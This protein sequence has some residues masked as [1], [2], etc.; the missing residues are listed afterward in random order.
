MSIHFPRHAKYILTAENT[1]GK[2][3][4]RIASI[5]LNDVFL[6]FS[7]GSLLTKGGVFPRF[8]VLPLSGYYYFNTASRR[9]D[10]K[11]VKKMWQPVGHGVHSS[12]NYCTGSKHDCSKYATNNHFWVFQLFQL[13]LLR[14]DKAFFTLSKRYNNIL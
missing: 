11:H 5:F 1:K 8:Y 3:L 10:R 9:N 4:N 12:C 7:D 2:I 6:G 13:K 14:H